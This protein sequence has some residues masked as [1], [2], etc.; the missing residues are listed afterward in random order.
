MN[1]YSLAFLASF[2]L[3]IS[4]LS[5]LNII[6]SYYFNLYLNLNSYFPSLIIPLILGIILFF[7][8]NKNSKLSIY[9]K[10]ITIIIGYTIFPIL[11]SLP[12]YF[13]IYNISFIDSYFEAI[14][15]FTSTGFSIF[16]NIKHL[17]ES[18]I[19]WRSTSQW[20]GGLYFLF[21]IIILI[22]IFDDNL[23]KSI[24]NFFSFNSSEILK[25]SMKI[26]II[27]LS[28]TIFIYFV[29]KIINF[30]D[31]D[32]FNFALTIIS[33][34][35][36]KPLNEI[37]YILN[38]NF[39]I[40]IFSLLLLIS[41]FSIFLIYNLI[42]LKNRYLNFFTEDYYLLLYFITVTFILFVFFNENNFPL[43]FLGITTSISNI[44][45]YF[46]NSKFDLTFIFLIFVI[47]GGSLL[48]TSSG[49]RFFKIFTLFKFTKNEILSY[50]KPK[51]VFLSKVSFNESKINY[52]VI[53]KYFLTILIFFISLIA[54]TSLLSISGISFTD[55]FKLGILTIMNTVNSSIYD[56]GNFDF[57]N[58]NNFFKI[59]LVLFMI[60]GRV[61]FITFIILLKKYLFKN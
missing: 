12:Y 16:D 20:I 10:I 45:I 60:I 37:N 46:S 56:L 4:F 61:E 17:D 53:N 38:S 11:I 35:G 41:F 47:I 39:K 8:K 3:F 54:V 26:F 59:T 23:K 6:Y 19:L 42:F 40:Y 1:R 15:G 43:L 9:N 52:S 25:Q 28:L 44:G 57:N 34:G 48:S 33:S 14:S 55:S 36:F 27:Y 32:A 5:L 7:F 49:I 2:S 50:I 30:R 29:L 22:D 18:L 51:Q 31:F 13:S 58:Q 24:T 21:S